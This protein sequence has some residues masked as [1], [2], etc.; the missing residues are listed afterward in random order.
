MTKLAAIVVALDDKNSVPHF[1]LNTKE[2]KLALFKDEES[3]E[4]YIKKYYEGFLFLGTIPN[5][6][7]IIKDYKKYL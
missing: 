4:K 6:A 3:A 7:K 5:P 1:V 2:E